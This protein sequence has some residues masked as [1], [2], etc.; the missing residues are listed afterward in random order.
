MALLGQLRHYSAL[1]EASTK[2]GIIV[3]ILQ[4]LQ[5]NVRSPFEVV[6]E[7]TL[8]NGTVDYALKIVDEVKVL[9]EVKKMGENLQNCE[10]QIKKYAIDKNIYLFILSDG[11]R[12]QFYTWLEEGIEIF[13][14]HDID[15]KTQEPQFVAKELIHIL[16]KDNI[17]SNKSY[18]YIRGLIQKDTYKLALYGEITKIWHKIIDEPHPSLCNLIIELVKE[19]FGRSAEIQDVKK[20][21]S[22]YNTEFN[23]IRGTFLIDKQSKMHSPVMEKLKRNILRLSEIQNS[24]TISRRD[25]RQRVSRIS[26]KEMEEGLGQLYSIGF[27]EFVGRKIKILNPNGRNKTD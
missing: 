19:S 15:I 5:W 10:N 13:K 23:K 3:P 24:D 11:L 14:F 21:L 9:I 27:C 1:N 6:R 25:I 4:E 18:D 8:D 2:S 12:W 7:Y 20:I 16:S 17:L 22:A 26:K